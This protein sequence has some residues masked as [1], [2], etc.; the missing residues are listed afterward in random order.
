MMTISA[1]CV[2][3]CDAYDRLVESLRMDYGCA[4][5]SPLANRILEAE[6]ADF[7][8]EARI[9]ER[10]LSQYFSIDENEDAELDRVLI[11][12]FLAARWHV[13]TC[14]VNG[15]GMAVDIIGLR[16]FDSCEEAEFAFARGR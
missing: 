9:A 4:D 15:E 10:Y 7:H 5:V 8:W 13:A 1:A 2:A 6:A 14:I 16:S 12:S 11:M 3:T